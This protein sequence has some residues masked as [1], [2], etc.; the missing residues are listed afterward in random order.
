MNKLDKN[1]FGGT[2]AAETLADILND[3]GNE[4]VCEN[5]SRF[6]SHSNKLVKDVGDIKDTRSRLSMYNLLH[7]RIKRHVFGAEYP[8]RV[9][10][11][12]KNVALSPIKRERERLEAA[13]AAE[14][15][16]ISR[17]RHYAKMG[18]TINTLDT[19]PKVEYTVVVEPTWEIS[20]AVNKLLDEG[21]EI[22]GPSMLS[23]KGNVIQPLLR[24][25]K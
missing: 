16:K 13:H 9:I 25:G 20:Q 6:L 21:W 14:Q 17:E 1:V 15:S 10:T 23:H 4:R 24:I 18:K 3:M 12:T 22:H 5:I 8:E 7:D 11:Y 19:K 2:K